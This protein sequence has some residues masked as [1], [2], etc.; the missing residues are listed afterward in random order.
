MGEHFLTEVAGLFG[1]GHPESNL[2]FF[3]FDLFNKKNVESG[4]FLL[5]EKR[6]MKE[7]RIIPSFGSLL[8]LFLVYFG[9]FIFH[10]HEMS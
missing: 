10:P 9:L 6:W 7:I 4:S 2:L 1:N 8:L 3:F 5:Y